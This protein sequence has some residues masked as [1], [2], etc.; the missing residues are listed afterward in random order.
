MLVLRLLRAVHVIVLQLSV[1]LLLLLRQVKDLL[2]RSDYVI[3]KWVYTAL[4]G[5]VGVLVERDLIQFR[6]LEQ[7]DGIQRGQRLSYKRIKW[8]LIQQVITYS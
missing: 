4:V 2:Q 3:V 6:Q 7:Q 5:L 1:Y 8:V